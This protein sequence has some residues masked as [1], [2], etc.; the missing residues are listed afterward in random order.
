MDLTA[1]TEVAILAL[2]RTSPQ[3]AVEF[4]CAR[5]HENAIRGG[6]WEFPGGKVDSGELPL[7]AAVRELREETGLASNAFDMNSTQMLGVVEHTDHELQRERSVRLIVHM[8]RATNACVP[9]PI[10]S[11][12]IRWIPIAQM[13]EFAWPTAN[14]KVI[15]ML[16]TALESA[17]DDLPP[18]S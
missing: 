2:W 14:A 13:H 6:L 9:S 18:R 5:R 16:R 10:G 15:P 8:A 4:L 3:G 17:R 7:D 1:P 12:E 11:T